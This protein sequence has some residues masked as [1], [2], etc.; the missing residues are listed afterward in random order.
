MNAKYMVYSA[1]F[2]LKSASVITA[3]QGYHLYPTVIQP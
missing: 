3:L 1:E 2:L